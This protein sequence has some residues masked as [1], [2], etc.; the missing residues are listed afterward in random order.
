MNIDH[1]GMF[2]KDL[3]KAKIFFI[4]YFNATANDKY[5][6]PKTQLET[7]FLSFTSGAKLEIMTKPDLIDSKNE[8][9]KSG[10]HHLAFGLKSRK[11]VDQLVERLKTDGY[12]I[13]S[14]PRITGDGYY[15]A[16]FQ[17]EDYLIEVV[18]TK[19]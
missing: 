8:S 1:I 5:Y 18:E 17:F 16:L 10:Y 13:I 11:D 3:E 7:Y 2:V 19:S 4:T 12:H 14:G 6:N 9:R 15:E